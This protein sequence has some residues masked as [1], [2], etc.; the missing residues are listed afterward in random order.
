MKPKNKNQF[1]RPLQKARCKPGLFPLQRAL[2][3]K[4]KVITNKAR[5]KAH[6]TKRRSIQLIF[7]FRRLGNDPLFFVWVKTM[8][9]QNT[10]FQANCPFA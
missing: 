2:R 5:N 10:R 8:P 9:A 1:S 4:I 6:P 7:F 3:L